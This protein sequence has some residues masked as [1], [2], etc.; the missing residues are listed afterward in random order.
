MGK[1]LKFRAYFGL[2]GLGLRALLGNFRGVK[3]LGFRL[4]RLFRLL[5]LRVF[6]GSRLLGLGGL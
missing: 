3:A 6:L 1:V 5:D 2:L 4:L